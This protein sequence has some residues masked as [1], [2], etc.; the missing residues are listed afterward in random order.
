MW[1]E[2]PNNFN[3]RLIYYIQEFEILLLR[4]NNL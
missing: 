4:L 2:L 3:N 1:E